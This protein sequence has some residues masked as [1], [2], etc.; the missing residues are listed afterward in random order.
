MSKWLF[1][2]ALTAVLAFTL[3]TRFYNLNWDAG[4]HLHPDERFLTM[5]VPELA[6]PQTVA[7]YFDTATSPLNPHNRNYPFYVYGTFPLFISKLIATPLHLDD[8]GGILTVGRALSALLDVGIALL[9]FAITYQITRN[10]WLSLFSLFLYSCIP[11]AIQLGHFFAVDTWLTF[12]LTLS[13]Y[14]VIRLT[15]GRHRGLPLLAILLGISFGLALASKITAAL[16]LPILGLLALISIIKSK[17]RLFTIGYWLM[18]LVI[19]GLTFRLAQPYFFTGP[20]F[21]D[22]KPNPKILANWAELKTWEKPENAPPFAYQWIPTKPFIYPATHLFFWGLGIPI[23]TMFV[24]G[25]IFIGYYL[26]R[27]AVHHPPSTIHRYVQQPAFWL[28]LL[29]ILELFY[30]QGGQFAKALRYLYPIMPFI[31]VVTGTVIGYWLVKLRP[32]TLRLLFVICTLLFTLW[33]ALAFQSVYTHPH[34]RVAA[35]AW[36]YENIPRGSTITT[37][38]WDDGIPLPLAPGYDSSWYK[39]IALPLYDPD[40]P[41]KWQPLSQQLAEADYI[42]L[43]SNRL[44]RSISTL[45]G[46]YPKSAPFYAHLFDGTLG[47]ETVYTATAYPCLIPRVGAY[48]NTPLQTD[49]TPPA[50]TLKSTDYCLLALNDD[51]AEESF[52]VYD[53]PKVIILKNVAKYSPQELYQKIYQ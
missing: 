9:V 28:S 8:Y 17:N 24:I 25:L 30:Y 37:E 6:F 22:L 19:C 2:L 12:F 44:W 32:A 39:N 49:T 14:L 7:Q 50:I 15:Q 13:F 38:I 48:R 40:T 46:K 18:A 4:H 1:P 27:L 43:T 41:Q 47:F 10:K 45:P 31:A 36:I 5:V 20:G 21:F 29:W 33:Y 16:F 52:T 3:F 34:T 53:H 26:L 42:F 23:A 51:G 11:T 35:S